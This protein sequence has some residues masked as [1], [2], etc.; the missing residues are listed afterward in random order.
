MMK[1]LWNVTNFHRDLFWILYLTSIC[2]KSKYCK[3]DTFFIG[4]TT[5]LFLPLQKAYCRCMSGIDVRYFLTVSIVCFICV[6]YFSNKLILDVALNILD[7][8]TS[9]ISLK[10]RFP[11]LCSKKSIPTIPKLK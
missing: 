2:K 4:L 11:L 3:C 1:S 5:W 8:T 7:P 9:S 6:M 10:T